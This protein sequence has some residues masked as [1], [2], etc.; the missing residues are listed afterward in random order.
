MA[1]LAA[2]LARCLDPVALADA[3]GMDPDPWQATVLRSDHP[4]VLLNCSRQSGKSSTCA[5]KAI[6]VAVYEPGALVLLL[7]PSQ[8]QSGELF[9]KVLSVYKTLGR[10]V[11]AEGENALSLTLE[12]GSRVISL[13]GSESTVRS[14]SA[15]RLLIIDEA[16]RVPDETYSA[17]RPMLAVSGGQ[18]IALSTPYGTRGWFY[19][20]WKHGGPTWQRTR[21]PASQCPRISHAFLAEEK[22][23]LGP[24]F[25]AQEYECDFQEAQTQA[26]AAAQVEALFEE[27][28]EPWDM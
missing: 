4:R 25:F 22:A 5:T 18:L 21:I 16:A 26:F 13:P 8:R 24:W 17:V 9:R 7:C 12:N 23:T 19:D 27:E 6:H 11:A 2:D 20:A 3:V 1:S 28:T 10:P 15:V 14:F